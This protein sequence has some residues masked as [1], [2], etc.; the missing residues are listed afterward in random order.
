MKT[1]K[2]L[3]RI[4][5]EKELMAKELPHFEFYDIEGETF[6]EGG[7]NI[8][9]SSAEFKL[10]L[11][12]GDFPDDLPKLFVVSPTKLPK[13]DGYGTVNSE[14]A[15]HEFHT[16]RNGPGGIVQIC[17]FKR[18]WWD[19]SKSLISVLMKGIYWL[20]CYC[21]YLK[22]GRKISSYCAP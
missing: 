20:E 10:R 21:A 6:V 22:T 3:Y 19:S 7:V 18:D 16:S 13:Y 8:Y 14:C 5:I 2:Q 4:G 17:H 11:V 12:L 1:E 15:S 9:G